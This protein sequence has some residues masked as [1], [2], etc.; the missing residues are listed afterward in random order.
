MFTLRIRTE[1]DAFGADEESRD[2]E[3]ARILRELSVHLNNCAGGV[4]AGTLRDVNGNTV[5][6]WSILPNDNN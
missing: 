2:L 4:E 3:I 5:G 6:R 1:S